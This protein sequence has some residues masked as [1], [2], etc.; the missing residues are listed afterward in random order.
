MFKGFLVWPNLHVILTNRLTVDT[1]SNRQE[2]DKLRV[3]FMLNITRWSY[4][5]DRLQIIEM[6]DF[7]EKKNPINFTGNVRKSFLL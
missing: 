2:N 4:R 7:T 1:R 3:Q 6:T 5:T